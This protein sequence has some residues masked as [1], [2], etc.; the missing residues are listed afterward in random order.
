MALK[1]LV[2]AL[3]AAVTALVVLMPAVAHAES[4]VRRD[5]AND[6]IELD[7]D[8][9]EIIDPTCGDGDIV[10]RGVSYVGRRLWLAMSFSD[11]GND[12]A[13]SGYLF[14]MRTNEHKTPIL[15][16]FAVPARAGARHCPAPAVASV[17][18]GWRLGSSTRTGPCGP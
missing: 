7:E 14:G 1:K 9:S 18:A 15:T 5:A 17:V 13:F 10:T 6:V 8:G 12:G 16:F 4:Y 11:L 2:V 3:I